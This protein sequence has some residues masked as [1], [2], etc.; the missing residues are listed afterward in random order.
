MI[1]PLVRPRPARGRRKTNGKL[2]SLLGAR[3]SALQVQSSEEPQYEEHD[4]YQA[5]RPAEPR[6]TVTTVPVITTAAE[7]QNE[8]D[9]NQDHSHVDTL[10]ALLALPGTKAHNPLP[11]A[12]AV[13]L[14]PAE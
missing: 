14:P 10:L 3:A 2:V 9:E 1:T 6:T 7:K 12:R 8:H 13:R 5:K 4:Q 11:P